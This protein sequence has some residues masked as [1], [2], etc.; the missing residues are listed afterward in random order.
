MG[1][2]NLNRVNLVTI[3]RFSETSVL[4]PFSMRGRDVLALLEE[5]T[6]SASIVIRDLS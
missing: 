3:L 6:T 4:D 1:S 2:V 5:L